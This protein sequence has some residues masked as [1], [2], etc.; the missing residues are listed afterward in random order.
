MSPIP[1]LQRG[2]MLQTSAT[3][4]E[5]IHRSYSNEVDVVLSV[6]SMEIDRLF[7]ESIRSCSLFF[8]ML[9]QI[10]VVTPEKHRAKRV[11]AAHGS[12]LA[13][14]PITVLEDAEVLPANLASLSPWLRQQVIKL[15]ADSLCTT[16]ICACLGADTVFLRQTHRDLWLEGDRPILYYNRYPNSP[17]HLPYERRRVSNVS[18]ILRI[19]PALSLQLGDFI[20]DFMLLRRDV[21]RELRTYLSGIYGPDSWLKFLPVRCET[22]E[23]KCAF[24]EW[25]LYAVFLL[26]I[27]Q[28]SVPIRN[29]NN[30][31][32]GQIHTERELAEFHGDSY[33]VHFVSKEFDLNRIRALITG[34]RE[35]DE[36]L[37]PNKV[38]RS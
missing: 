3:L 34:I 20:M 13:L 2:E 38:F 10:F 12:E 27:L 17:G 14:I 30:R 18:R 29:S 5:T 35:S 15:H 22:L 31:I 16:Q 1:N 37:R 24:G 7:I 21:L 26:E 28:E 11:L 23:D 36:A 8:P 19:E 25:T 4:K 33:V 9:Q 6:G 32:V